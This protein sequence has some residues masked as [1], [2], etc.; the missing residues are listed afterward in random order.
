M[1]ILSWQ[2]SYSVG[3]GCIDAEHKQLISMINRAFD[4]SKTETDMTILERLAADMRMYA[5]VHFATEEELM[6]EYEFPH[7]EKH[8]D[9]HKRFLNKALEAEKA[10]ESGKDTNPI[11]FVNFLAD[12]LSGHILEVDKDLGAHLN[13]KGVY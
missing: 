8:I 4:D 11:E 2:E 3:V 5:M 12:W 10:V 7:S 9:N 1:P 13:A 6:K